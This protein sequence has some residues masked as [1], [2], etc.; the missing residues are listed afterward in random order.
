MKRSLRQKVNVRIYDK[1]Q[2]NGPHPESGPNLI[3]R[4]FETVQQKKNIPNLLL[5]DIWPTDIWP[6]NNS[7]TDI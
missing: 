5:F 7:L 6:T 2:Q 3:V 1:S 4:C